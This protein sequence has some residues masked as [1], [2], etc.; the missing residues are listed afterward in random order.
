MSLLPITQIKPVYRVCCLLYKEIG[1]FFVADISYK[2]HRQPDNNA[3]SHSIGNDTRWHW[4]STKCVFALENSAPLEVVCVISAFCL[5]NSPAFGKK[6]KKKEQVTDT[7]HQQPSIYTLR[8]LACHSI[9]HSVDY[10]PRG[11]WGENHSWNPIL[12]HIK[13]QNRSFRFSVIS[14]ETAGAT[15]GEHA[16]EVEEGGRDEGFSTGERERGWR[17]SWRYVRKP[18]WPSDPALYATMGRSYCKPILKCIHHDAGIYFSL[19]NS[20]PAPIICWIFLKS[21]NSLK[22]ES[23]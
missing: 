2:C 17:M 23:V 5:I 8:L 18:C 19:F 9:S 15:L 20:D 12:C 7:Y 13:C 6:R 3:G 11:A 1:F 4:R 16:V 14:T 10:T 21:V 22:N